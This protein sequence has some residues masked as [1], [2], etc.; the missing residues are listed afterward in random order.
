MKAAAPGLPDHEARRLM[1]L[2]TGLDAAGVA[3]LGS[4]TEDQEREFTRLVAR[5]RTGEPLQ[6]IEGTVQFGPVEVRVD[7]RVLI[8]RPETELLWERA[9]E[10]LRRGP[11]PKVIV[12]MCTGSGNLALGLKHAFPGARV[13]ATDIDPDAV[14]LATENVAH[15]GI[16]V[17]T[18]SL[19][20]ALPFGMRGSIDLLVANPPYVADGD[21]LPAEVAGYEPHAALFAGPRGDEVLAAIAAQAFYWVRTG[22]W[23]F[24][25]I[26]ET[27]S[28]R[29][30][31]L[32]SDFRCEIHQDMSGRP[33]ILAGSRGAVSCI[34]G[35]S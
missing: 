5:R 35:V 22:G 14:A 10:A 13:Y 7:P 3:G 33:R 20:D 24:I 29:A 27:Q 25:E 9:V 12:D 21:V 1:Q 16:T 23:V 30:L 6:Y 34:E 2:A 32:F 18:G 4:L 8:P 19:F 11:Q 17:L 26:G 31:D 28:D 15:A